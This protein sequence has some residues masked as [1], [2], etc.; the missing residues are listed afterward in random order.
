MKAKKRLNGIR[1]LLTMT[2]AGQSFDISTLA[3][4]DKGKYF[5]FPDLNEEFIFWGGNTK[6]GFII[7]RI[8]EP[9]KD[10]KVLKNKSVLI[11]Y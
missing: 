3:F 10:I 4:L 7:S 9:K 1:E 8:A 5:K 11:N 2:E 6:N